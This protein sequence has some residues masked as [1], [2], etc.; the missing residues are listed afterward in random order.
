MSLVFLGPQRHDPIV[1]ATLDRL[2]IG[3]KVALITAGW[4]ER[5]LEDEELR[6]HLGRESV[7]LRI[8]ARS[9][10]VFSRSPELFAA[11]RSKQD[12]LKSLQRMYSVRLDAGMSAVTRLRDLPNEDE[13]LRAA[14]LGAAIDQVR[15]LDAQHNA[16]VGQLWD[17]FIAQERPMQRPEVAEIRDALMEELEGCDAVLIAGGH[18]AILFNRLMLFEPQTWLRDRPI[19]AW[20]AGAMVLTHQMV[21][22]HDK[23][24]QGPNHAEVIGPGLGLTDDL[25]AMP[26][27]MTRIRH[28]DTARVRLLAHRFAPSVCA[29]LERGMWLERD[30][31]RWRGEHTTRFGLTGE[32]TAWPA[33]T[34]TP[35]EAP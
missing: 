16:R 20:S 35:Q 23:A 27:A 8:Y 29:P 19:I 14:Q 25:I 24:A 30:G 33:S 17:S 32:V 26:H 18:V 10:E 7:N 22:F 34:T 11:H 9:R 4:Q 15:Q 13:V 12:M 3:P 1:R 6:E 21:V 28:D 2:G 31:R 5:E